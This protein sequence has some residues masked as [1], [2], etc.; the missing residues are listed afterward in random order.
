MRRDLNTTNLHSFGPSP[1]WRVRLTPGRAVPTPAVAGDR[2]L[3]GGGFGTHDFYAFHAHSGELAWQ[4]H[5]KDDGP[6]AATIWDRYAIFNTESCTL[7]VVET[8]RGRIVAERW[9]GDPLLAQP[10]A[11]NG[12][13]FMVFPDKGKHWLGAF[14]L[15]GLE[16]VW[17]TPITHDVITT[18]VCAGGKVWLSTFDG[19]VWCVD[20]GSGTVEW[21][22]AMGATSAPWIDRGAVYVAH[23]PDRDGRP[24]KPTDEPVE[25]TARLASDRGEPA[26][27]WPAKE[28]PY[29]GTQWGAQRKQASLAEDAQVGFGSAPA[30]AK[31]G[32][33]E[34]LIGEG[35]VSRTWRF[36]G[37]RPVV[38]SGMLFDTSGNRLEARDLATDAV[39][40]S[41]SGD[42][43]VD[44][45][46][47][48]TAPAVA[49]DRVWVGTWGGSIRCWDA[50]SGHELW[51]V[52]VGAPCHWQPVVARGWVYAG[53]ED[54]SLIGF[55][56]G[57]PG[58]D[59]WPMWGGGAG[60]NGAEAL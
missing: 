31:L 41:Y 7:E 44:G 32:R 35:T 30:S 60:H 37:S 36:Q 9:L 26:Y 11:A 40:W 4:L 28:A 17:R 48:L 51:V 27:A 46:R 54:G 2:V 15:P 6:T 39:V 52:P 57:D 50:R 47:R 59:G 10:T 43:S 49:N 8:E 20:Q 53:L 16:P 29:L 13:V 18:P 45:E 5:T 12:R 25:R 55:D 34:E 58:D 33:A 24:R 56:T 14:E 23:R 1:G 42:G 22:R 38:A 21:T 19:A 3:V